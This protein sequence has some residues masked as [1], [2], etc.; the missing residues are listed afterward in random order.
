MYD[1]LSDPN[2]AEKKTRKQEDRA[3]LQEFIAA[4]RLDPESR[5]TWIYDHVDLP[6]MASYLAGMFLVADMDCCHKNYYAYRDSDGSG[7]WWYMPWDLDLSFGHNWTG[8]YFDDTLYPGAPLFVG[9]NNAL[10][11][12]LITHPEW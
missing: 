2:R 10:L 5:R 12:A 8:H 4:M 1:N 9:R 7:E 6:R 3:D 11:G